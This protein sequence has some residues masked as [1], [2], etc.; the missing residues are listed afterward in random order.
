MSQV[1][2]PPPPSLPLSLAGGAAVTSH[3][4]VGSGTATPP[5]ASCSSPAS[6]RSGAVASAR[7]HTG[8]AARCQTHLAR[9]T[10]YASQLARSCATLDQCWYPKGTGGGCAASTRC[11]RKLALSGT[12]A[13]PSS[14]LSAVARSSSGPMRSSVT[15]AWRG[16]PA[17]RSTLTGAGPSRAAGFWCT[18]RQRVYASQASA[19]PEPADT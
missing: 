6:A 16:G 10:R 15:F 13:L 4:R 12:G 1:A 17:G 3:E 19:T 9:A 18:E 11:K 8:R 14:A 2:T 5:L 7:C